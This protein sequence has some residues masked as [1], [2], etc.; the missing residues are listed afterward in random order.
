MVLKNSYAILNI[1]NSYTLFVTF[2]RLYQVWTIAIQLQNIFVVC[3]SFCTTKQLKMACS[4]I[5]HK[6]SSILITLIFCSFRSHA[7]IKSEQLQYYYRTAKKGMFR[8]TSYAIFN[9]HNSYTLIVTFT[10]LYQV[11]TIAILL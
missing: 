1:H 4:W 6:P 10:R 3:Y 8:K 9:F 7:F 5:T 11:W 2:T